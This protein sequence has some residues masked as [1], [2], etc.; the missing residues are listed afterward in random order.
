[1]DVPRLPDASTP[2]PSQA[3]PGQDAAQAS[4][5]DDPEI[6]K[7]MIR[8]LLATL[9]ST[10]QENEH[11]QHKVCVRPTAYKPEPRRAAHAARVTAGGHRR[12]S[13]VT[14]GRQGS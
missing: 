2:A 13:L 4:L 8:E 7:R 12:W 14:V 3:N 1:M 9:R 5:P 6:L 10:R 11:L